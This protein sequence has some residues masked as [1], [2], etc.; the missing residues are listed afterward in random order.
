MVAYV[1]TGWGRPGGSGGFGRSNLTSITHIVRANGTSD[2]IVS[3]M[4]LIGW[5]SDNRRVLSARD[6]YAAIVD[7]DGKIGTEFGR[8]LERPANDSFILSEKWP[9]GNLRHQ[10]GVSMPHNKRL[11]EF[12][13]KS[14]GDF[15]WGENAGG[16]PDG[17][18][19]GPRTVKGNWE[20]VSADGQR[21]E[22]K[23]PINAWSTGWRA[24]WSPDGSHIII[25][26]D[27]DGRTFNETIYVVPDTAYVIDFRQRKVEGIIK[28]DRIRSIGEWDYRK[29]RC[30]PWSRDGKQL[31]FVRNGQVWINSTDG[32]GERQITFDGS[33]KGF[34]TFSPDGSKVAYITWQYDRHSS[35]VRPGPTDIWVADTSTGLVVRLTKLNPDNIEDLDW[36]NDSTII[37]DRLSGPLGLYGSHS[38]FR[39]ISLW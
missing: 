7:I 1:E 21:F 11:A 30:N 18:W 28:M 5:M 20:F 12:D 39:T 32:S 35:H 25:L 14:P 38:R 23:S 9:N 10:L 33:H 26:P 36:L 37:F 16:S 22:I 2:H 34:P 29:G 3:D 6:G 19:F 13:S 8:S 27:E 31:A 24:I 17:V 15:D 4:F